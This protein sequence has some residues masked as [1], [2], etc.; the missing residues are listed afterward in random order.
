MATRCCL[1]AD[2]QASP[3]SSESPGDVRKGKVKSQA[4]VP[5]SCGAAVL[6]DS[7]HIWQ[8]W[9][10]DGCGRADREEEMVLCDACDAGWHLDCLS[11]ALPAV[12]DGDW[13]CLECAVGH[14][15]STAQSDAQVAAGNRGRSEGC[16]KR[17]RYAMLRT[18]T[19]RNLDRFELPSARSSRSVVEAKRQ[20]LP[21]ARFRFSGIEAAPV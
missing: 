19:A 20:R 6:P 5:R 21:V 11:P 17:V 10:C 13:L 1:L 9:P 16:R 8:E 3:E 4:G 7:A 12:P 18:S 15:V 2:N 14:P